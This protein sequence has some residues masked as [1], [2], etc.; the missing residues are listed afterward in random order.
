[1]RGRGVSGPAPDTKVLKRFQN[2]VDGRFSGGAREFDDVNPADGTVIGKASAA[3]RDL[4]D[5][6]VRAARR[7]VHGPWGK[8]GV[9][10]RAAMLYKIADG[11]ERRF[12]DFLAA[13]VADTGKPIALARRL[14]IPRGAA[15]FRTFADIIKTTGVEAYQSETP[16]GRQAQ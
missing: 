10:E 15:N 9:R 3:D 6:A 2:Y 7:A 14:D 12:D 4:V 11:I 1:M 16:D 5:A 8:A 13:E